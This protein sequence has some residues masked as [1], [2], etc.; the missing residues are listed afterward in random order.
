MDGHSNYSLQNRSN[1]PNFID[2]EFISLL[3]GLSNIIKEYYKSTKQ[4]LTETS[5]FYN[6]FES[7]EVF[8]KNISNEILKRNSLEK[9]NDIIQR[10]EQL[11]QTKNNLE[12]TNKKMTEN[13]STFLEK[14]KIQFKKMKDMKNKKYQDSINENKNLL[15]SENSSKKN[16][17]LKSPIEKK[18]YIRSGSQSPINRNVNDPTLNRLSKNIIYFLNNY[19]EIKDNLFNPD[20]NLQRKIEELDYLQKELKLQID[21]ILIR[22]NKNYIN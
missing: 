5:S 16:M 4:N 11:N 8:A 6:L 9:I 12:K 20:E 22:N 2:S 21:N 18:I 1:N 7:Q 3:N 19:D 13:L 14:A 17:L 15:P 10:L